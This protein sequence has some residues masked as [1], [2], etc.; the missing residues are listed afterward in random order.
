MNRLQVKQLR[1]MPDKMKAK[2]EVAAHL[3]RYDEA[4]AVYRD[5]DRK[6]LAIALRRRIGD[7]SRV[8]QLLQTGGGND[9]QIRDAFDKIGEPH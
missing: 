2:A 7:Y 1:S 8:V 3:Q 6:D 9:K 5:I 4:E